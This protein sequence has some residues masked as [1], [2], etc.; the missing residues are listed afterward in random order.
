PRVA[1]GQAGRR[2]TARS[3]TQERHTERAPA[4]RRRGPRAAATSSRASARPIRIRQRAWCTDDAQGVPLDDATT[5]RADRTAL[6]NPSPH[7]PTRVRVRARQPG[8]RH[9]I[10]TGVARA[11]EHPAHGALHRVVARQVQGLLEGVEQAAISTRV[12]MIATRTV[13]TGVWGDDGVLWC[14]SGSLAWLWLFALCSLTLRARGDRRRVRDA[15]PLGAGVLG[16]KRS[17]S[18]HNQGVIS[19][20]DPVR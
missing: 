13:G 17:G 18:K 3:T 12:A 14:C 15:G 2:S 16:S 10:T 7:A 6:P 5:G 20:I 4:E 19:V 8:T 11:Q 1:P 9:S